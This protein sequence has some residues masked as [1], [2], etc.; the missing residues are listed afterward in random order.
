LTEGLD[1]IR[2]KIVEIVNRLDET[3]KRDE[4][5][6]KRIQRLRD[7]GAL[8][9]TVACM[10]LTLNSLRN[11]AVYEEVKFTAKVSLVIDGAWGVVEE[12][13]GTASAIH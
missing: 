13:T 8:P 10:M 6:S 5:L 3:R 9:G 11:L 1:S 7:S 12:W 2:R 4:G